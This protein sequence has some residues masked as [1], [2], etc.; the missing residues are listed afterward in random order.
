MSVVEDAKTEGAEPSA[1]L[2]REVELGDTLITLLGTAHVSRSSA[3]QVAAELDSKA[4]Q[5][6]AI[7][8]CPSRFDALNNPDRLAQLDL[9]QVLRQGKAAMVMAN[10]PWPPTNSASANN[11]GSNPARRCAWRSVR[12]RYMVFRWC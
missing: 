2:L 3:E 4:Y 5:A 11:S 8:L 1:A 10:L 7:E 6:V 9:M 12:Q